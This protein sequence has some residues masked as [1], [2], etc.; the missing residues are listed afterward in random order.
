VS[1][2][3]EHRQN[4]RFHGKRHL[5]A[6]LCLPAGARLA[7]WHDRNVDDHRRRQRHADDCASRRDGRRHSNK[8]LYVV[9]PARWRRLS[10]R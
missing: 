9:I 7:A 5:A 2:S 4:V 8:P 3:E 10:L 6:S 1:E